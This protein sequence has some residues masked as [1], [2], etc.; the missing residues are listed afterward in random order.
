MPDR[1][2]RCC[3]KALR[4]GLLGLL[5]VVGALVAFCW[6]DREA[7]LRS[8]ADAWIVS[9]APGPADAA[10]IFG[11]GIEDRPFAAARYY[12]QGLVKKIVISNVGSGPAERLGVLDPYVAANR[13][14]LLKLGVPEADIGVFGAN[15]TNTHQEAVALHEWARAQDVHSIIIPTEP[16]GTRRL[17]WV[18]ARE[19]NGDASFRV[20]G[21]DYRDVRPDNWWKTDIGILSF[22]NEIIKYIYYRLKY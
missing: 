2:Q 19:F 5:C 7:V 20:V 9:D 11:G 1:P 10:A 6:F 17:R 8:A 14:V 3:C 16:F 21:T 4:R 12:R 22:Q 15:L 18:L 13:N